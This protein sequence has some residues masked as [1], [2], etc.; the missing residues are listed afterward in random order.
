MF[1]KVLTSCRQ[2]LFI[3][4]KSLFTFTGGSFWKLD[5]NCKFWPN[6]VTISDLEWGYILCKVV[7]YLKK[8]IYIFILW[9]FLLIC[10]NFVD[11]V[12][13]RLIQAKTSWVYTGNSLSGWLWFI[14]NE[15]NKYCI[16]II[17]ISINI[18]KDVRISLVPILNL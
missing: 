3:Q 15:K 13:N 6:N 11:P 8:I 1:T 18:F 10:I 16:I 14:E 12:L 4:W 5:I 2:Q 17:N 7:K 9:C